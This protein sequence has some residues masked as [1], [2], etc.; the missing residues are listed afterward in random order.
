MKKG[1]VP[2]ILL[3]T[4][5]MLPVTA[6]SQVQSTNISFSI[7]APMLTSAIYY[8][9]HYLIPFTN[10]TGVYSVTNEG[11]LISLKPESFINYSGKMF[12]LPFGITSIS[13]GVVNG[14]VVLFALGTS[15]NITLSNASL[16]SLFSLFQLP[17]L[18]KNVSLY[19]IT[20]NGEAFNVSTIASNVSYWQ[21]ISNGV[22]TYA[23]GNSTIVS[24]YNGKIGSV[25]NLKIENF[26]P[27]IPLALGK[28]AVSLEGITNGGVGSELLGNE[29]LVINTTNGEIIKN[30][31]DFIV[32][33]PVMNSSNSEF[34][35]LYSN[36]SIVVYNYLG[37]QIGNIN[38]SVTPNIKYVEL[39][40][41]STLFVL[42]AS[43]TVTGLSAST[44][45]GTI[46]LS[47]TAYTYVNIQGK[48]IKY[49]TYSTPTSSIG[50]I[51]TP[52]GIL[53]Y[54]SYY[55]IVSYIT[56]FSKTS[57]ILSM[58]PSFMTIPFTK[59]SPLRLEVYTI[60]GIG[61]STIVISA[62]Y[63]NSTLIGVYNVK[64]LVNGSLVGVY[65]IGEDAYYTV[66]SSGIYNVTAI[67]SNAFGSASVSK[68]VN[69]TVQQPV[70]TTTT[71][72][73]TT[74][75]TQSET[76]TTITTTT[77]ISPSTTN[78]TTTTTTTTSLPITTTTTATSVISSTST[79]TKPQGFPTLPI[80]VG[81]IVVVVVFGIFVLLRRR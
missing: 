2:F 79:S 58:T 26:T 16:S 49:T 48:W 15:H 28:D 19:L 1:F 35:V 63:P 75:T 30:I 32:A 64:F 67:V 7:V 18:F 81:I 31:T 37:E 24:I 20:F 72:T 71:T 3:L 38:I 70:N 36:D 14:K 9:G 8:Q 78:T 44:V 53:V 74:T 42:S 80:I 65:S 4:I 13:G 6:N 56:T 23:I 54:P 61:S 21:V 27:L 12:D 73:M 33:T 50:Q 17:L 46:L 29:I 55:K 40:G 41:N 45:T 22:Y 39:F 68:M 51:I 60:E 66:N 25:I 59:P 5:L 43:A 11:F 10:L 52:I 62:F 57:G 69:V 47:F 77:T 76:N 34:V